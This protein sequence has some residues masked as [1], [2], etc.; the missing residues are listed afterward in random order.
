MPRQEPRVPPA[1][2][3][4]SLLEETL[5][6]KAHRARPR[7]PSDYG[8]ETRSQARALGGLARVQED[9]V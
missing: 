4:E 8:V 9:R 7:E 5:E 3:E 1:R 2:Q 6:L